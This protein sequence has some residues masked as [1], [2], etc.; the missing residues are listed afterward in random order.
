[1]RDENSIAECLRHS[2]TVYSLVGRD[3]ETKLVRLDSR[4]VICADG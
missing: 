1:M 3:Y 2:D 4:S